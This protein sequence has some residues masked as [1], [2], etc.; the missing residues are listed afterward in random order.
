MLSPILGL[1]KTLYDGQN[2]HRWKTEKNVYD[3]SQAKYTTSPNHND[4]SFRFYYD[5]LSPDFVNRPAL[6]L[7]ERGAQVTAMTDTSKGLIK[8]NVKLL[9]KNYYPLNFLR[10]Y[11]TFSPF[12]QITSMSQTIS[13]EIDQK[14]G[15]ILRMYKVDDFVGPYNF[16]GMDVIVDMHLVHQQTFSGYNQPQQIT[17][18][19]IPEKQ[20]S[21]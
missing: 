13:F 2:Y 11:D 10:S 20:K 5:F 17:H 4:P 6:S 3:I 15:Y 16:Q 19:A 21:K 14:S 7:N 12:I 8:V 18:P 1:Q 9:D